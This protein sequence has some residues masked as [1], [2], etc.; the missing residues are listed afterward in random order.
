MTITDAAVDEKQ[1]TIFCTP[2]ARDP[3]CPDCGREGRYRDTVTR[4]L[5]DLPVAGYP[6][7][8]KVAVPRYRCTT[9]DCGRAVFNQDLGKLAA[10]RASTTRRCSRYVLRR[11]LIDR[12]TISAI[13]AELGVSWHTVSTIAMRTTADR[14]A[15]AGADRLAGVRVIGVDEHRWAP[16]RIGA[17]GFVT[18]IIDLTPTRDQT[19]PARLLDMVAGRS[20]AALTTWLANQPRQFRDQV[21]VVAMDGF[22]GSRPPPPRCCPTRPR[23]W[24]PSMS[25]RWLAPS[26]I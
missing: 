21:E 20:A 23:S 13:A 2:V 26:W 15:A 1:T 9:S 24:T 11:L 22:G 5:T 16:R 18:L 17:D 14:I 19:G 10:P 3:R 25:S 6:L 12:T 7:A 8:L 4:P